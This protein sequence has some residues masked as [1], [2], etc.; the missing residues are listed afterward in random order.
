MRKAILVVLVLIIGIV[1]PGAKY[2][3]PSATYAQMFDAAK[4]YQDYQY[5][6]DVYNQANSTFEDAKN[7]YLTNKTLTLKEDARRKLLAMLKARDQ[8]ESVYLTAVRIKI[9]ETKGVS[10]GD[11]NDIFGKIDSEV[12]WYKDRL[13]NYNDNEPTESLFTKNDEVQDRYKN[14]TLPVVYFSLFTISLGQEVGIRQDH[15][16]IYSD[17]KTIINNGVATGKLNMNPFNRWFTDID[18]TIESLKQNE[19]LAKTKAQQI[20]TGQNYSRNLNNSSY[21]SSVE[22]LDSSIVPLTQIN[23]FLTEV[24]TSIKNQQ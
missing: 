24:L 19:S 8:L 6:L 5:S 17:L 18:S 15:E 3:V 1:F 10:D 11:K 14:T 12:A 4:A 22:V 20:F 7:F 9:L 21:D 2:S 13:N 23:N 16:I